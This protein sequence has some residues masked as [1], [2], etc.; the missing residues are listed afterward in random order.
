MRPFPNESEGELSR[1]LAALVRKETCA[2]VAEALG[3]RP[4]DAARRGRGA[5]RRARANAPYSATFARRS[6]ARSFSTAAPPRPSV[7][8]REAFGRTHD[9]AAAQACATPRPPCRNGRRRA[10]SRTPR[11]RLVARS[12][13]DHAPFFEVAV[14]VE[15]LRGGA[16]R[17]APRS[18]SPNRPPRRHFSPARDRRREAEGRYMSVRRRDLSASERT[19]AAASPRWSARP[20]PASRR[21]SISSSAPRCRS[22]RARRRR[23]A[24]WC[25]ASPS[26]ARRRSS[27]STRPAS[28][29]P[30]AGSTAPWWRARSPAPRD[31]DVIALLIDARKGLDDEVEAI[32]RQLQHAKAPKLLV[33][34]KID[35][36]A[37]ERLLALAAN[38]ERAREIRRD[39]H[40]LGA[41]RRRRRR[42]APSARRGA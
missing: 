4:I 41:E 26:R 42:S 14:E 15:G 38:A 1:R 40:D 25:A 32:L 13:P 8:V 29:S 11:Y 9:G 35:L 19:R 34:N 3:R 23:R 12:G 33:L 17:R 22:S 2:E 7:V 28:S 16:R 5:D 36:I 10:A 18:A 30:S 6:S 24:R 21:C 27:S 39:L 37:R 31:A 20:T